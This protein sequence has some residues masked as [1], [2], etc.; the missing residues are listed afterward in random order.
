[1]RTSYGDSQE[2]NLHTAR[3]LWLEAH[4]VSGVSSVTLCIWGGERSEPIL[5]GP[6]AGAWLQTSSFPQQVP[7]SIFSTFHVPFEERGRSGLRNF[8]AFKRKIGQSTKFQWQLY[9]KFSFKWQLCLDVQL[10]KGDRN[11]YIILVRNR[12]GKWLMR[13]SRMK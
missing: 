11:V 12:L 5:M 3:G 2:W 6:T 9:N 10:R 8:A 7:K 1:M 4:E 13:R